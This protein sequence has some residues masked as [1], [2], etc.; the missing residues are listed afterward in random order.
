MGN[1]YCV[2][3]DGVPGHPGEHQ[4]QV[5]NTAF[6]QDNIH[7]QRLD[8]DTPARRKAVPKSLSQVASLDGAGANFL[9]R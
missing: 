9:C 8:T 4:V 3:C 6:D 5:A 1:F 7:L 2:E